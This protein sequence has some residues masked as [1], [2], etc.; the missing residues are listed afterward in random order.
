M[1]KLED[2]VPKKKK[3]KSIEYLNNSFFKLDKMVKEYFKYIGSN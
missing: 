1:L 3:K 2:L